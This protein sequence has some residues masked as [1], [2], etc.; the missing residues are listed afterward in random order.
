MAEALAIIGLV[1]SI[2]Q[3]V[4]FGTKVVERLNEFS[5]DMDELS[6]TFQAIQVQLPL[7]IDTLERTQQQ[8]TAGHVS[9]ATAVA[10][11][12]LV[13]ACWNEIK[14]LQSI[15]DKTLPPKESPS[16]KRRL[17]ALRSLTHDKDVNASIT[18]LESH[19]R[20]L[21]FHQST[22]NSDELLKL[23]ISPQA[24]SSPSPQ[25]RKPI[26]M[27]P[28]ERDDTFVGR[29]DILDII[30]QKIT[31]PRRRAVLTGIGGVG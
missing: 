20:L 18:K 26:F 4:D 17:L 11:K 22:N 10:L 3:F 13:D 7:L 16:W 1:S 28:F 15:L 14:I 9:Y 5:S 8:A 29:Q 21:T 24:H 6:K 2:V 12:P 25:L 23:R 19:I 31:A 27:V 30:D